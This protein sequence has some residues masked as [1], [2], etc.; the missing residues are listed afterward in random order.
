MD[1]TRL[2]TLFL[3]GFFFLI[4]LLI[5]LFSLLSQSLAVLMDAGISSEILYLTLILPFIGLFLAISRIIVGV[6]LPNTFVPLTIVLTSFII[7][8]AITFEL[9]IISLVLGYLCKFL[10]SEFRLHFAVKI[11][12]IISLLSI[13]LI[14]AFP[15]LKQD[16]IFNSGNGH[17]VVIY[18]ILIISLINEKY[19]TFKLSKSNIVNDLKNSFNTFLFALFSYLILGGKLIING[20]T[21]QLAHLKDFIQAFPESVFWAL[22]LTIIIGRYTGLRLSEIIRFRKLIFKNN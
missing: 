8:P 3:G 21:Y 22:F 9:M 10:I 18:G 14:L 19:I 7:G 15:L 11:S 12:V 5:S 20:Q 16:Q 2:K 4:C 17:M 1:K 6:N 13:G